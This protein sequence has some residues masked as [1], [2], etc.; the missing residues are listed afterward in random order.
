[1]IDGTTQPGFSGAPLVR[2]DGQSAAEPPEIPGQGR[3]WTDGLRIGGG[4]SVVRGLIITRWSDSGIRLD[5]LGA[6]VVEGNYIGTD[7]SVPLGNKC[8]SNQ[9]AN[10]GGCGGVLVFS[11]GN[12]IGGTTPEARNVI[13]G[14]YQPGTI[15][16]A[17]GIGVV[18]GMTGNVISGNYIG[19]SA[20]GYASVPN[21]Y[22]ITIGGGNNIIGGMSWGAG[23]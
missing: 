10:G 23:T 8:G 6:N 4:N 2:L 11:G 21:V 5:S 17:P 9:I 18:Q 7:G 13:S 1:M 3:D 20:D 12:R 14:Q 19:I 16:S 15:L 22:G